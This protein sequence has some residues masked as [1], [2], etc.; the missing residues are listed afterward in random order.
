MHLTGEATRME[1]EENKSRSCRW[2]RNALLS[3]AAH[4]C[5]VSVSFS[6]S[7]PS[8]AEKM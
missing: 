8:G 2:E 3:F 4:A 6:T 5:A 7:A 1:L